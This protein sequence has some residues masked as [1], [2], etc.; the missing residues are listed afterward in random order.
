MNL[1]PKIN[2]YDSPQSLERLLLLIT[3]LIKYPGIGCADPDRTLNG[4][5]HNALELVRDKLREI[6]ASLQIELPDN[7]PAIPTIRKDLELLKDYEIL[8]RRMYRWGYYLGTGVM[9]KREL[10]AAFNALESQAIYQGDPELRKIYHTLK[11]RMKGFEFGDRQ[12]FFYPVRQH[13]NRAINYTD[14]QEMMKKGKY[15]HTLFHQIETLE[16]AIIKGQAIE[17][18]RDR[19]PYQQEQLGFVSVYPLQLIYYDIAWYLIYEDYRDCTL[20]VERID[21]FKDHLKIITSEGR[22]VSEQ[23]TSLDNAHK[24]LKNGWGLYLGNAEEQQRELQGKLDLLDFKVRFYPPVN[25]FIAEG[26]LRHPRQSIKKHK[27]EYLDYSVKLPPRSLKEFGIWVNK[28][29][30]C[31]MVLSP[32]K[33]VEEHRNKALALAKRYGF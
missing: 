29:L 20:S 17:L 2:R 13:L 3:T 33:L 18:F 1:S 6:A 21:R 31:A 22:N 11:R 24:L 30:D 28:Y 23:K 7:Y 19:D 16:N 4:K 10:K 9:N 15:Q 27:E 32:P 25:R 12:D 5:H 14:P 8:D 26:E